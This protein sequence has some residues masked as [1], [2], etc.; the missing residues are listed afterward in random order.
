MVKPLLAH[1]HL[2]SDKG[3]LYTSLFQTFSVQSKSG[4]GTYWVAEILKVWT[5]G[6]TDI[7]T[8]RHKDRQTQGQT[9]TKTDRH[10]DSHTQGQ[11]C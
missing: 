4:Q 7:R 6:Q 10:K 5:E 2:V 9:D 11:S 3:Y 1:T 8:D